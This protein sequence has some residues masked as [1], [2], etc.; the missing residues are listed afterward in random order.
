M[1]EEPFFGDE[2]VNK[3]FVEAAKNINDLYYPPQQL[4]LVQDQDKDPEQAY[5]DAVDEARD[6][7]DM[8]NL[9]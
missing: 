7:Y 9:F 2:V 1:Y 4:L 8:E 5:Q 6:M 3:Y